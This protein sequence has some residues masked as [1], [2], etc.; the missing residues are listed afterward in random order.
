MNQQ[1]DKIEYRQLVFHFPFFFF[2]IIIIFNIMIFLV[3]TGLNRK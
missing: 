2:T 3:F 1:T